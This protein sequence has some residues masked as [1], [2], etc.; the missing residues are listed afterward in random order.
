MSHNDQDFFTRDLLS[1]RGLLVAAA[2]RHYRWVDKAKIESA[3]QSVMMKAWKAQE[4]FEPN[5]SM[6]AWLTTIMRNHFLSEMRKKSTKGILYGPSEELEN[7]IA[8]E[9]EAQDI[10]SELLE[11]LEKMLTLKEEKLAVIL[12]ATLGLSYEEMAQKHGVAE[13]TIKS[14]VSRIRS[15]LS[16]LNDTDENVVRVRTAT[17]L[18]KLKILKDALHNAGMAY[19]FDIIVE[20]VDIQDL[21]KT[22]DVPDASKQN[23]TVGSD[24]D[25]AP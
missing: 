8:T 20:R 5:S 21:E 1:K 23:K 14:R 17:T 10:Q 6:D 16:A 19:L 4:S 11:T 22:D 12:D 24:S 18:T 25:P 9:E 2:R 15:H 13:G 7:A 3:V